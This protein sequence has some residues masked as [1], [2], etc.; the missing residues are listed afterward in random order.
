MHGGHCPVMALCRE[1]H[2]D[3]HGVD[4][5]IRD[6]EGGV[7]EVVKRTFPELVCKHFGHVISMMGGIRG[8]PRISQGGGIFFHV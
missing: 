7:H 6:A 5:H 8:A 2:V 1:H 4:M 3:Q